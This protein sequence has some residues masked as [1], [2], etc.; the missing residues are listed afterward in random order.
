VTQTGSEVE[1]LPARGVSS[2]LIGIATKP[3]GD[4]TVREGRQHGV[5]AIHPGV[6]LDRTGLDTPKQLHEDLHGHPEVSAP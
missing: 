3:E 5:D 4:R 2:R 1:R 6:K